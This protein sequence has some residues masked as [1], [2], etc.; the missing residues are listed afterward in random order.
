VL[1]GCAGPDVPPARVSA[2]AG[3]AAPSVADVRALLE[4]RA[5]AVLAGDPTAV[6]STEVA[7]AVSP[8]RDRAT[9]LPFTAWSY[10]DVEAGPPAEGLVRVEARLVYRFPGDPADVA[11]PVVLALR[12]GDAGWRVASERVAGDRPEPWELDDPV[13]VS[14]P[15]ALVIG[16]GAASASAAR[17][18]DAASDA[19]GDVSSAVGNA[20]GEPLSARGVVVVLVPSS[21]LLARGLGRGIDD[22]EGVGAVT[23]AAGATVRGQEQPVRIW[24]SADVAGRLDDR[25]LRVL[26]RHESVHVAAGSVLAPGAP[27]WLVEGVAEE[28]GY[29][30]DVPLRIA[31]GPF[32]GRV[33][34]DGAPASLP[35]A[36]D[37]VGSDLA[38]GYGGAHV[39]A[40]LVADRHGLPA[41][42]RLYALVRDGSTTVDAALR[43]DTGR[44]LQGFTEAW[45]ARA[46]ELAR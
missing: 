15:G 7:G 30:E 26:M 41:L 34:A 20:W 31:A 27:A 42:L 35:T 46:R 9:S 3:A 22:L 5:R 10:D 38:V 37:L 1:A 16:I 21:D 12:L 36:D 39:A 43:V 19:V 6:R 33:A 11:V 18:A 17:I 14:R 13:A 2:S 29:G 24:V 45:R 40:D 8:V 44:G 28:I 32:L 4:T 23:A 25:G